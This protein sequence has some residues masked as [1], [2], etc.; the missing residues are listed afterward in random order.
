[1]A[2]RYLNTN[3]IDLEKLKARANNENTNKST[4]SWLKVRQDWALERQYDAQ[5]ENYPPETLDKALQKVYAEVC[6]KKAKITSLTA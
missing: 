2:D 5:I 6:I 4:K 1:M 3:S